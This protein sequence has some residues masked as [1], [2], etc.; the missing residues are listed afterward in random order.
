MDINL[1][2]QNKLNRLK[3]QQKYMIAK[4]EK[5]KNSKLKSRN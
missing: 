1:L 2:F 3:L 4:S 5:D